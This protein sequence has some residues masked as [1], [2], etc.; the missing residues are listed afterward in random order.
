MTK[1]ISKNLYINLLNVSDIKNAIRLIL[2]KDYKSNTYLLQNKYDFKIS[3]IIADINKYS[4]N[5][6]KIKWLRL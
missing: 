3:D 4:D 1:I 6:I 5:K 2:K